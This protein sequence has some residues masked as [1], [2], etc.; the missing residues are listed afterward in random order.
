M[1]KQIAAWQKK[2]R[3][4]IFNKVKYPRKRGKP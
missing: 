1:R 2:I 4:D 3:K